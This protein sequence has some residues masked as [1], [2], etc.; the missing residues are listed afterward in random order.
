MHGTIFAELQK[1]VVSNLGDDAWPALKREAGVSRDAYDPLETYPDAEVG[2]LVAAASRITG[3]PAETLLENF[4]TFIAPDLLEMYWGA[5]QPE[6]RTLEL[7]ENTESA[8]H[9]VVRVRQKGA[10]PPYLNARRTGP[11]EVTITYTSPRKLCAVAK[12]IVRGV[13]AHYGDAI[14]LTESTCML[15]G[16]AACILLVRQG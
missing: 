5:I 6:W 11:T 16:D 9:D 15:R 13:A 12:G 2:A 4:G 14:S 8:I 3:A 1:Y 7:L 10:T